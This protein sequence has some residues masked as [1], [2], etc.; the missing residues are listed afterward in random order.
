MSGIKRVKF[1][2]FDLE[3]VEMLDI[4]VWKYTKAGP[5]PTKEGISVE[6]AMLPRVIMNCQ[7]VWSTSSSEAARKEASSLG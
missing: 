3:G 4:R 6:V 7:K 1:S 5:R 2:R